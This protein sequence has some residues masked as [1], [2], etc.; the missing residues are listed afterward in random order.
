MNTD[1]SD[2][3]SV[4][5]RN[6]RKDMHI[7]KRLLKNYCN[8]YENKNN[9]FVIDLKI[10]EKKKN[11]SVPKN[12]YQQRRI[13][14]DGLDDYIYINGNRYKQSLIGKATNTVNGVY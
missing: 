4:N 2:K 9:D 13:I 12:L 11:Q 5:N 14:R 3:G 6:G 8:K 1:S 7:C 10:K